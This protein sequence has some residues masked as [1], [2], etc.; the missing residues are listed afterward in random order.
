M[1]HESLPL[2]VDTS[3]EHILYGMSVK[4]KIYSLFV[5]NE[6]AFYIHP[7]LKEFVSFPAKEILDNN[8]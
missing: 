3:A 7:T 2:Y 8:N 5:I 1:K 6:C 4:T